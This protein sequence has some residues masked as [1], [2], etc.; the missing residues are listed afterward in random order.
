M[1]DLDK[2]GK[3]LYGKLNQGLSGLGVKVDNS[4]RNFLYKNAELRQ[5]EG[6]LS[7]ME[8]ISKTKD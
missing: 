2:K 1:T 8:T 7:Y 4:F 3:D 6:L 5:I